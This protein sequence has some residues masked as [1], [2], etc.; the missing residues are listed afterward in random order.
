MNVSQLTT[1]NLYY[2]GRGRLIPTTPY[3]S[4][5]NAVVQWLGINDESTIDDILP[6]RKSFPSDTMLSKDE[7]FIE[8]Q[9][10]STQCQGEGNVIFCI[11][12][13][14]TLAKE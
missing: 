5:W 12:N 6:N 10:V 11:P 8:K 3:E 4:A 1:F 9:K 7:V 14:E 13:D 2:L